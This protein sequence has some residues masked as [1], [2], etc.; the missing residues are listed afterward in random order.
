[1]PRPLSIP[2]LD[3]TSDPEAYRSFYE[4]LGA[5]YPEAEVNRAANYARGGLRETVLRELRPS[6]RAGA[7]LV[8]VGCGNGEV[9]NAYCELGGTAI[10]FDL[11]PKLVEKAR[12]NA[13]P[14]AAFLVGDAEAL[15]QASFDVALCSE[16]LEHVQHPHRLLRSLHGVLRPGGTLIPHHADP[17]Q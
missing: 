4:K 3:T 9:T 6:S 12:A 14:N 11:A 17:E 10:G 5:D 8:D 16:V 2:G 13:H 15:D 1:M 7:S